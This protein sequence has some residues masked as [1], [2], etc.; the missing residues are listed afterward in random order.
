[1]TGLRSTHD[2]RRPWDDHWGDGE[3]GPRAWHPDWLR[4]DVPAADRDGGT[5][6][7]GDDGERHHQHHHEPDHRHGRDDAPAGGAERGILLA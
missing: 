3:D 2:R 7:A 1:M 4:Q 6:P 5:E